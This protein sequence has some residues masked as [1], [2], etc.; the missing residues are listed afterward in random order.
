[1]KLVLKNT[2]GELDVRL[3]AS[4]N[5]WQL[6]SEH[7]RIN[8]TPHQ[9][10]WLYSNETIIVFIEDFL[11][12]QNYLYIEG[13]ELD[14]VKQQVIKGLEIYDEESICQLQ[15]DFINQSEACP[16][17]NVAALMAPPGFNEKYY[18]IFLRA[19]YSQNQDV[20]KTAIFAI[21]Y[22]PWRQFREVLVKLKD[23]FPEVSKDIDV[24][25]QAN[26]QHGWL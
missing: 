26:D 14:A 11:L 25:I 4:I 21:T 3:I 12:N 1:M 24:V 22:V 10:Q 9:I 18:E 17:I 8:N 7:H 2:T 5:G 23:E 13:D 19:F 20:Q 16:L 6:V 15:S